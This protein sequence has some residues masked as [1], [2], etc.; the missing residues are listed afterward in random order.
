MPWSLHSCISK[1]VF[2]IDMLTA[3]KP[4][5]EHDCK[6]IVRLLQLLHIFAE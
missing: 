2:A 4:P 5:L 6:Y 1:E 3:L